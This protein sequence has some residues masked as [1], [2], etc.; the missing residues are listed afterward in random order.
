M[1]ALYFLYKIY[2]FSQPSLSTNSRI[3]VHDMPVNV[4]PRRLWDEYDEPEMPD[5]DVRLTFSYLF[6]YKFKPI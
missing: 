2:S 6:F 1:L 4:V 5:F 3:V